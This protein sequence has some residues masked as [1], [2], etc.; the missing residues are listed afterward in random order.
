MNNLK[1]CFGDIV[2][3]WNNN[4]I[5]KFSEEVYDE[6]DDD[7]KYEPSPEDEERSVLIN[8]FLINNA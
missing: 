7:D 8:E 1:E 2:N 6:C 3:H 5:I 4:P